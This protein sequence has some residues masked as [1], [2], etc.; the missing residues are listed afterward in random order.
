LSTGYL[1]ENRY[2]EDDG[3]Y[4]VVFPYRLI[5]SAEFRDRGGS[6]SKSL[7]RPQG[8]RYKLELILENL[9][10]DDFVSAVK[11]YKPDITKEELKEWIMRFRAAVREKRGLC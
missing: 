8:I 5:D 4:T 9:G 2:R 10:E 1:E 7:T 11:G 6:I 3:I